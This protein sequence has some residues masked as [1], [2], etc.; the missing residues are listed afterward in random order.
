MTGGLLLGISITSVYPP[1]AAALVPH[2]QSSLYSAPGSKKWVWVSIPPGNTY[3]PDASMT[4]SA[5]TSQPSCRIAAIFSPFMAR[6]A[7]RVPCSNTN[8][9]FLIILSNLIAFT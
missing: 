4:S 5:S 6:H 7:F 9:P 1:E 8:V 3:W 2:S